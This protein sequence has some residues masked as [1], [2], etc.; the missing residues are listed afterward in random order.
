[1]NI[2]EQLEAWEEDSGLEVSEETAE[3]SSLEETEEALELLSGPAVFKACWEQ[4]EALRSSAPHS[5]RAAI[6]FVAFIGF[7]FP[8]P[9][10]RIRAFLVP[11]IWLS[12]KSRS[13]FSRP[14]FRYLTPF[15]QLCQ[16]EGAPWPGT[17]PRPAEALL[18]CRWRGM[19]TGG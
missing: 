18:C 2:R 5:S 19:P 6:R 1:M 7:S 12:S 10:G 8:R 17:R 9:K 15:P 11:P 13:V 16:A 14:G 4:A 3:D